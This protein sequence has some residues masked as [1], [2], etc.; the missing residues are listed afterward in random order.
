MKIVV[1]A[2]GTSTERQVSIVSGSGICKALRSRGHQAVLVDIFFGW[3]GI[4]P[5]EAFEKDFDVDEMVC[6]MHS[7]DGRLEDEKKRRKE[8]F[9]PN[10]LELCKEA[11]VV[12]MALHGSNG[13]DGRVQAC[14]DL[15]G[16][17]YTGTDYVS[18]A[19][20]MDKSRAKQ[21]LRAE[22]VSVPA[23]VMLRRNEPVKSLEEYG[24]E[25]PVI[26]KPCCG[27]SS[28]G[29]TICYSEEEVKKGIE[30]SF[31]LEET[32]LMEEFIVGREFTCA[33]IDHKAYPVVEIAP[34]DGYY[35]FKNKYT[36]GAT[37]ETCPAQISEEKTAEM[38]EMAV[39]AYEAL[40]I[41]GYSR[42]DFLM[43]NGDEKLYCLEC[44]TLPG[45]TPT[46]LVP[47]E[48]MA[49]GIDYAHLCELLI[50]VSLKKYEA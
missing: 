11:D 26:I 4:N 16:I 35:D 20:A 13:E 12:F 40:G 23:G 42:L 22:G 3:E 17:R 9:G 27:G 49:V 2:A 19:I 43:R 45:M 21:V 25:L 10:V 24:M 33:V 31:S 18:S 48:A 36:A 15:M 28:V 39:R 14:F 7:F 50:E 37:V 30:L 5:A 8:F 32:A 47:Q 38:Q 29:V 41:L 46:S 34:K 6:Y 44:N 1:L